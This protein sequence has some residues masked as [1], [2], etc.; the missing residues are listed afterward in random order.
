MGI[1]GSNAAAMMM[2]ALTIHGV[3]MGP[4]LLKAQPAFLSATFISMIFANIFMIVVSLV[5]AKVFTQVLKIPYYI[6]G[7]FIMMLALTGT[8]AYQG[9]VADL[10]IMIGAGIFGYFFKKYGF[11]APALILGLV[12]GPMTEKYFRRGMS[13][14]DNSIIQFFSSPVVLIIMGIFVLMYGSYFYN[15]HKAKKHRVKA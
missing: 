9:N 7:T 1:P 3:Q 8:Y 14:N 5:V 13:L 6:L 15:S 11:N 10:F 4:L 12:L 2:A